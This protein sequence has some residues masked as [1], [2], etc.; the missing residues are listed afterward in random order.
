MSNTCLAFNNRTKLEE[1]LSINKE[2]VIQDYSSQQIQYFI[3]IV[4]KNINDKI[5]LWDCCA[6]SGGKTILA[7]DN[8]PK[9]DITVSDVRASIIANLRKR[10]D[11]AG[12][13]NY[14]SFTADLLKPLNTKDKYNFIICDVPCSG[15]GTWARTPEQNYFFDKNNINNY[16]TLQKSISSHAIAHLSNEGYFLYITCSVLLKEN[17][18]IVMYILQQYP[19]LTL[20]EKK[21][22]LGYTQQADSMF[23]ALFRHN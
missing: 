22:F 5:K 7:Y 16:Q 8:L 17:E 12:I 3:E 1:V 15:S 21:Y 4:K 2:V 14:K 19:H 9:M 6:A 20:I 10:F 13:K 23:G 18:D 11:E